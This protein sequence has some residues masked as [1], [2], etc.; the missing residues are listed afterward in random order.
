MSDPT[1]TSHTGGGVYRLNVE[2]GATA[3]LSP[4]SQQ[5]EVV[6]T[7]EKKKTE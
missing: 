6:H 3:M 5:I 4:V 7:E 1:H 2:H